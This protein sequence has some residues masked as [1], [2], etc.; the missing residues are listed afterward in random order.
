MAA[1]RR[2]EPSPPPSFLS[3]T[4]FV[5]WMVGLAGV[6]LTNAADVST[7]MER[8]MVERPGIERKG[9]GGHKHDHGDG[10]PCSV[11]IPDGPGP[12]L[13]EQGR[14]ERLRRS[15]L[16]GAQVQ[17]LRTS[18]LSVDTQLLEQQQPWV[19]VD[20]FRLPNVRVNFHLF[21]PPDRKPLSRKQLVVRLT[22]SCV[23][24]V[25]C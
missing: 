21:V 11:E 12:V 25:I 3:C 22:S 1:W 2:D 10:R 18:G 6:G 17:R 8:F 16:R 9:R 13:Q 5:L 14:T 7:K 15:R 24:A 19:S 20:A 23:R 4:M